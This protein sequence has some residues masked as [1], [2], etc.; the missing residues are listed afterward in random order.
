MHEETVSGNSRYGGKIETIEYI[1]YLAEEWAKN[2]LTQQQIFCL[3]QVLKYL[4]SRLGKKDDVIVEMGKA[5]NY[6]N[7]AM[8]GK[9]EIK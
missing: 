5:K 6:L 8:T 7:R 3:L 2:G 4:S 9:W 1:E